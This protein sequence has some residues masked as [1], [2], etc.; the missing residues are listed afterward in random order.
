MPFATKRQ[1]LSLL[2]ADREKLEDLRRSRSAE[3]RQVL[4][5]AILLECANGVSGNGGAI[6][7]GANRHPVA[8]CSREFLQVRIDGGLG[9]LPRPWKGCHI[10]DDAR[11]RVL[12]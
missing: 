11:R 12:H 4:H 6:A 7:N 3:K 1:P 10:P 9:E 2:A 8:V 5:A